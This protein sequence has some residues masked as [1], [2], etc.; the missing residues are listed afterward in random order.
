MNEIKSVKFQKID[1][2]EV[3]SPQFKEIMGLYQRSFPES[4]RVSEEIIR[5]RVFA[6]LE[7]IYYFRSDKEVSSV[8]MVIH[9]PELRCFLLDYIAIHPNYQGNQL[10]T[11]FLHFLFK[12]CSAT[13]DNF[14]L[15]A[16]IEKPVHESMI[17]SNKHRR[18]RWYQRNAFKILWDVPYFLPDLSYLSPMFNE[19]SIE[20]SKSSLSWFESNYSGEEMLLACYCKENQKKPEKKEFPFKKFIR[21]L[22]SKI[23]LINPQC[24]LS[25]SKINLIPERIPL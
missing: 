2:D 10:G 22:Y 25:I 5:N 9:F 20:S 15:F 18:I 6:G 12:K 19:K 1:I 24:P 21:L 8:G 7:E 14:T 17:K 11:R 4:E 16:E 23:Y 13:Y 3:E